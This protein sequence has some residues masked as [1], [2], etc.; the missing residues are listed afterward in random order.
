MNP[1]IRARLFQIATAE[2][3]EHG[4]AQASLNRII[5]SIG[6]SKSSFY[7]FF[8]SKTDLFKQIMEQTLEPF[9]AMVDAFDFS[10]LTKENFWPLL[11][12]VALQA[13]DEMAGAPQVMAVGRMFHRNRNNAEDICAELMEGPIALITRL[14]EQGKAVGAI[15]TDIPS[16]LM[17]DMVIALG[18]EVDRWVLDNFVHFDEAAVREN[19]QMIMNLF[20]RLLAPDC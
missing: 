10:I 18:M 20:S 17:L 1:D 5:G 2:F 3:S 11:Q 7:H 9:Q 14:L 13:T 12:Q 6:M 8:S 19:N 4:F 16:D 15:R